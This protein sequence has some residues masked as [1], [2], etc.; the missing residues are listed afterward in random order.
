M[1]HE[2]ESNFYTGEVPWHKLGTY[3]NEAPA[4]ADALK[5][6]KL[7]W[8]V[9]MR[10]IYAHGVNGRMAAVAGYKAVTRVVDGQVY[11]VTSD[12]Y[13]PFQN[14]AAFDFL[15]AL[16]ATGDLRYETAGSLFSGK[17]VWAL[18]RRP[19]SIMVGGSDEVV[20]YIL[21][22]NGHDGHTAL[23]VLPTTVRVVCNNT[24]NMAWSPRHRKPIEARI[25][26][27]Q[28]LDAKVAE[29]RRVL[30]IVSKE[31]AAFSTIADALADRDGL[32]HIHKLLDH[33][34]PA[35][36]K[37]ANAYHKTIYEQRMAEVAQAMNAQ[38]RE[39]TTAWGVLNGITAWVDHRN[40]R[41]KGDGD[42]DSRKMDS[43]MFGRDADFKADA[44]RIIAKLTKVDIDA[45]FAE[46]D[47]AY[48]RELVPVK[49][50]TA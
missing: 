16:V 31:I 25:Y 2:I 38:T 9:E 5:L 32:P 44:A 41:A 6:A 43:V 7:D 19:E 18:A 35:P 37:D 50:R 45:A 26:H 40:R 23:S 30:G 1:A 46:I 24:L 29:A 3:I 49:A 28:S 33:L 4:G 20:P 34:F 13:R 47:A 11:A 21:L 14:A 22:V 48:E 17:K 36:P 10:P 8:E 15:E 39:N 12:R 42:A 27:T